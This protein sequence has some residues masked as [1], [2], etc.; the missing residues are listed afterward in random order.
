M[1]RTKL[2]ILCMLVLI[3]LKAQDQVEKTYPLKT[4]TDIAGFSAININDPYLSPLL[5]SG[6]GIRYT[7]SERQFF[8]PDNQLWSMEGKISGIAGLTVN[9]AS[10]SSI[11]YAAADYHWGAY[12]HYR[13][14]QGVQIIG[15]ANVEAN[16]G[17]KMNSRNVNN[18]VNLDLATGMNLSALVR[19]D[20]PL[21]SRFLRLNYS[22]EIPFIG[23]MFVPES[24]A[25]Y[26]EMYTLGNFNNAFHFSS[27]FNKQGS[28]SELSL[29]VPFS[30]STWKFGI[31]SSTLKYKANDAIYKFAELGLQIGWK[32]DLYIFSGLK[33]QAPSNFISTEK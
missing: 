22:L 29:D 11:L 25:S 8:S 27:P 28:S 26:Y 30:H 18:P 21:R 9:P 4:V 31:Y 24:G 3:Q 32:Y 5:Y 17:Y 6:I 10:T 19:Y 23:C 33:N 12:Y 2:I 13:L 7:H 15:G 14:E 20:I 16:F 1:K